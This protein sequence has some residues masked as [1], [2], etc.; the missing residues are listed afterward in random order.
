MQGLLLEKEISDARGEMF[1]CMGTEGGEGE[2][3]APSRPG[4]GLES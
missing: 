2:V 3:N 1:A 4:T